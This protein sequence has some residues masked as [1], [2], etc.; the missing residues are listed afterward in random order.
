M[1]RIYRHYISMAYLWLMLLECM[2]FFLVM[3]W[4]TAIRLSFINR[5]Y[6]GRKREAE[7]IERIPVLKFVGFPD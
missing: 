5:N 3:Y 2:M 4:S 1:I 6:S 7:G